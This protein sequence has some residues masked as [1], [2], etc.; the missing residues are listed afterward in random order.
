MS[1]L[2]LAWL[3]TES[4]AALLADAA[5][6]PADPLTRVTHL[7]RRTSPERAAAAVEML[8]LRHRARQRFPQADT[9][10]FTAEGLE[11][12]TAA[13][14]AHYRA[15]RFAAGVP[16]LDACCGIG[17]DAGALAHRAPVVAVDLNP[18]AALCAQANAPLFGGSHPFHA[19]CADITT[20]DLGRW[21]AQGIG[22]ALF[23]PSRRA[24]RSDG[25]R[26]R[27]RDASDYTP[28]LEFLT[29]LQAHFAALC[30]KVSPG[31]D[32]ETL[33]RFD[34]RVEF[35]SDRG[36][37]KEAA[38]WFGP[39]AEGLPPTPP[40]TGFSAGDHL[41]L[42]TVLRAHAPAVTL[43]P[44]ACDAPLLSAP[45]AWLLEPDP[46]VIR[47]HLVP[48]VAALTN[49]AQITP[50]IAYLTAEVLVPTPFATAYR[51]LDWL[52]YQE[53]TVRARL[54][55]L[56]RRV[57]VVKK[58]DVPLE[59]EMVRKALLD[60]DRSLPSCVLILTRYQDKITALICDSP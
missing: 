46:A 21:A 35:L 42:A 50:G 28:P 17:G 18:T 44:F 14:I 58:R 8:E 9:L 55:Q 19:L 15:A 41:Y 52:P 29:T 13:P 16:V 31:L 1:P 54:R 30:V 51:I 25:T 4:G 56:G 20:L 5:R 24:D 40:T 3:M 6:L 34:T 39:L 53:K 26:R 45:R 22:A 47:A 37:C 11:Q 48:Q 10:F 33:Q 7:R 23:D 60:K 59:P 49:A 57:E 27:V 12:A 38:L 2:T 43:T 36:E 32:D